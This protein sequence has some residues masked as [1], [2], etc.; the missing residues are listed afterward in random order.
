LL[1]AF[2]CSPLL[3]GAALTTSVAMTV[4]GGSA[5][6]SAA[7]A[8]LVRSFIDFTRWPA[9]SNPVSLCIVGPASNA[10]Q[11]DN[12]TTGDGRRVSRRV[13]SPAALAGAGCQVAYFGRLEPAALRQAVLSVRGKGV[14]TIAENDPACRSQAMFC[15]KPDRQ[16]LGFSVNID[17]VSRSGLKVDP[18]VLRMAAGGS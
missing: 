4:S 17:A 3:V 16:S 13:V 14:L 8:R 2:A 15:L 11:L 1:W 10:G 5:A 18:R 6:E 7:T 12:L 9:Q